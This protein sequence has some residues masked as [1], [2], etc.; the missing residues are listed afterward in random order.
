MAC[1]ALL[2][3]ADL[4]SRPRSSQSARE[5]PARDSSHGLF[6]TFDVA[7]SRIEALQFRSGYLSNAG[8]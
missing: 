2:Q 4:K 8:L 6:S 1:E 7:R 3:T 5:F